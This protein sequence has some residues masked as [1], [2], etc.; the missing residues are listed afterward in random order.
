MYSWSSAARWLVALFARA[1]F[2]GRV[3]N[4]GRESPRLIVERGAAR[5][6]RRRRR[7]DA[8][9]GPELPAT[10]SL[11]GLAPLESQTTIPVTVGDKPLRRSGRCLVGGAHRRE[12]GRGREISSSSILN[13]RLAWNRN[14][15]QLELVG[16][17][18]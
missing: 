8:P 9:D 14:G 13:G 10:L 15:E 7:P 17:G 18:H 4:V 5:A 2:S 11:E 12:R 6:L 1:S 16:M 3:S